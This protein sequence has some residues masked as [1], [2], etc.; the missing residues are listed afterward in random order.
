VRTL[1]TWPNSWPDDNAV[2]EP[3][4]ALAKDGKKT[5]HQVLGAR[6]YLQ[7][8]QGTK[9]LTEDAKLTKI[10]DLWPSLKRPEEKRSAL[11]ALGN[12]LL[13]AAIERLLTLMEDP[14]LAEDAANALANLASRGDI[15]GASKELRVKALKTAI[16]KATDETTKRKAQ[17]TLRGLN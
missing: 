10:N 4:L 16:P 6:G 9:N 2:A 8:V 14:A 13:P 7:Y 11:A 1:S 12:V 17:K 3:L 15:P 5:L